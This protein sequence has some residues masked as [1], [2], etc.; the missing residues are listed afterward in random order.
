M[1]EM[2]RS[3]S[4]FGTISNKEIVKA[5]IQGV[6]AQLCEGFFFCWGGRNLTLANQRKMHLLG[7]PAQMQLQPKGKKQAGT[8]TEHP[9]V[10]FQTYGHGVSH[11][12]FVT[13][14]HAVK[15]KKGKRKWDTLA[16]SIV[17]KSKAV[18]R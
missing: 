13:G 16:F 6:D 3:S 10:I 12:D 17:P 14:T 1:F 8:G 5:F 7:D 9:K 4:T 15:Q 2:K 11:R 18:S